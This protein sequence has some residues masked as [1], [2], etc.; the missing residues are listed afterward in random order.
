MFC[1]VCK[2]CFL[3]NTFAVTPLAQI[4][5]G[6]LLKFRVDWRLI[7]CRKWQIK[8]FKSY[9]STAKNSNIGGGNNPGWENSRAIIRH[10]PLPT[11]M[12]LHFA[13]IWKAYFLKIFIKLDFNIKL[14]STGLW[15]LEISLSMICDP[16]ICRIDSM[17]GFDKKFKAKLNHHYTHL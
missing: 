11:G 3:E 6:M 12:F 2:W 4:L 10:V 5:T 13:L 7:D 8:P 14:P 9:L 16:C 1:M 15:W 17:K